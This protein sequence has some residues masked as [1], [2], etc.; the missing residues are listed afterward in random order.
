MLFYLEVTL[1]VNQKYEV[2][3]LCNV[4]N[5]G[6]DLQHVDRVLQNHDAIFKLIFLQFGRTLASCRGPTGT[7]P[8]IFSGTRA[9]EFP[10]FPTL[11]YYNLYS[12]INEAMV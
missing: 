11:I 5:D 4:R 7:R 12:K 6:I 3:Y 10:K 1:L 9:K 8:K 2:T